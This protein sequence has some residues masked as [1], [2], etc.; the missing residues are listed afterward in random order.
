MK[1][2]Y[3]DYTFLWIWHTSVL[4]HGLMWRLFEVLFWLLHVRSYF[5]KV[6][7][8][9]F[10]IC[11]RNWMWNY[12]GNKLYEFRWKISTAFLYLLSAQKS[13]V[14]QGIYFNFRLTP[15]PLPLLHS[16]VTSCVVWHLCF[17]YLIPFFIN[18]SLFVDT[19][20]FQNKQLLNYPPPPKIYSIPFHFFNIL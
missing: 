3:L 2:F 5:G 11:Y 10:E 12:I 20:L 14:F 15:L 7:K 6:G 8:I 4:V 16:Y 19:F 1:L 9:H 13:M 18:N 17:K